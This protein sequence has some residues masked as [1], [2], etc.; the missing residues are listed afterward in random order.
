MTAT[1]TKM[2]PSKKGPN[3]NRPRN[4][5]ENLDDPRG[6]FG[7]FL[8]AWIDKNH[9]GTPTKLAGALKLK[10]RTIQT[11]AKGQSG[12][13]FADLNRVALAMGFADWSK[14]AVAIVRHNR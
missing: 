5:V 2:K 7:V 9:D 4:E 1:S 12:P 10:V 6:Q 8:R 13:A 11:W 14:L 3:V